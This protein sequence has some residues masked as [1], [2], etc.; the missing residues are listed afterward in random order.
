ML[1]NKLP[2][3]AS[4]GFFLHVMFPTSEIFRCLAMRGEL[5]RGV[6]GADFVGFQIG[7][8]TDGPDPDI[9][10]DAIQK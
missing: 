7:T 8:G 9:M 6:P 5:L 10:P 4:I 2:S 3:T 1:R